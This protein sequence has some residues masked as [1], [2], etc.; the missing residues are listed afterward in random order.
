MVVVPG[1]PES[2]GTTSGAAPQPRA[3]GDSTAP[4]I[5]VET[6]AKL[7]ASQ[8]AFRALAAQEVLG[9]SPEGESLSGDSPEG[10]WRVVERRDVTLRDTYWDTPDGRLAQA[11]CTLR[12]REQGKDLPAELTLKGPLPRREPAPGALGWSRTELTVAAPARSVPLDW[13]RLPGAGPVIAA[14]RRL[15]IEVGGPDDGQGP[16]MAS[17]LGKDGPEGATLRPDVVLLNP[18]RELVLERD[19]QQCVLSL[20]EVRIEGQPY[21]RRYV[22][23]ELKRGSAEAL[24]RLAGALATRYRLRPSRQGKVQA[25]RAWL[26]RR[27]ASTI[28]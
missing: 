15:G 20:D 8:R 7:L 9:D 22:E 4:E 28:D 24:D 14:L 26:A 16:A 1:K 17:G 13:A 27:R 6:E 5:P 19:G 10:I 12:V 21:R 11:R 18:R 23:I 25:A 3:P 2:L